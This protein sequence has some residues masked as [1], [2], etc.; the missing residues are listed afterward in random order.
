M[1]EGSP[2]HLLMEERGMLVLSR[3][4][5]TRVYINDREVILTVLRVCG[6]TVRL[7][8]EAAREIRIHRE[9]LWEADKGGTD[10]PS[11]DAKKR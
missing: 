2:P 8:F 7:G 4:V 5:G 1:Q 11:P 6:Q 9:E 3:K 10:V